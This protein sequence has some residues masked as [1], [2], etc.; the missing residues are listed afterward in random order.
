MWPPPPPPCP[1]PPPPPR[2][3]A[4]VARRLPASTALAKIIITRPLMTFSSSLGGIVRHRADA[5]VSKKMPTSRWIGDKEACQSSLLNSPSLNRIEYST[6]QPAEH[7][8][9]NRMEARGGLAQRVR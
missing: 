5:G 8:P 1:P 9:A 3:C 7:E 6:G 2:A 4:P